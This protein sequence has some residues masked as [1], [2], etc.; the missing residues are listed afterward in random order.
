[1]METE[2]VVLTAIE[3]EHIPTIVRWRNLPAVYRGF[4]EYAPLSLAAQAAFLA[5]LTPGGDRHLWL[6]KARE[7]LAP[8]PSN[9]RGAEDAVPVGTV[10]IMHLDWRNRRCE[11]GPIFIGELEY[12]G[13][14]TTPRSSLCTRPQV[15][16]ATSFFA[17]ISFG[18]VGSKASTSSPASRASSGKDFRPG[19]RSAG[20]QGRRGPGH[21]LR[22]TSI[23]SKT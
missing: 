18:V 3:P 16:G 21:Q 5:G 14:G 8:T 4:I 20:D 1:M 17:T 13:R 10:G 7:G 2:R 19:K 12:R 11:F 9:V 23:R 22:A 15:S 6:I